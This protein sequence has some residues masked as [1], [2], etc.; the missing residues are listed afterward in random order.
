MSNLSITEYSGVGESLT[1]IKIQAGKEPAVTTQNVSY[2][3]TSTQSSAFN[4]STRVV[5]IVAD[6]A[7]RV[8]FGSNPTATAGGTTLIP[9]NTPEYFSVNAGDKVAVIEAS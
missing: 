9:A 6:A 3:T 2:T 4:A 1:G 8:L 5:R 7:S